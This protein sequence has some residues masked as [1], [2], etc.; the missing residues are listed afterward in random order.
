M[1]LIRLNF[2]PINPTLLPGSAQTDF[3][4]VSNQ[5]YVQF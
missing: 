3:V 2:D 4:P 1:D 5:T